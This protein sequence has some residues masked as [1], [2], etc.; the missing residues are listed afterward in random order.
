MASASLPGVRR[1]LIVR[2]GESEWNRE[3]RWQGWTDSALSARGAAQARARGAELHSTGHRFAAVY[4]SDLARAFR[5]AELIAEA[6]GGP[7]AVPDR[8]LRERFGGAWEGH[9]R[10]EI[11]AGWPD[12]REAWQRGEL[13]APPGGET[14]TAVLERVTAALRRIDAE[15][16]AG[17]VL[18]VSHQGV[19]RQLSN[20]ASV[21]P[22]EPIANLGG[23]WFEWDGSELVAGEAL[24]VLVEPPDDDVE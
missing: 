1:M 8:A 24:P 11:I 16:P 5:T 21:P 19:V 6:V 20:W 7:A 13:A 17:A 12:E 3:G 22:G 18:V 15:S 14:G 2:H 10:A 9:T 4:A 23:R